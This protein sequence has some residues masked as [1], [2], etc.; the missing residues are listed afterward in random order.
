MIILS[1]FEFFLE[2]L[3]L[4]CIFRLLEVDNPKITFSRFFEIHVLKVYPLL[5]D[6]F[7]LLVKLDE[8]LADWLI[9][10]AFGQK[11][12]KKMS[13][14]LDEITN[15]NPMVRKASEQLVR[16][17]MNK[18]MQELERRRKFFLS[19][20]A[21]YILDAKIEEKLDI[22]RNMRNFGLDFEVISQMTGL[23]KEDIEKLS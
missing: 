10:F 13:S 1:K 20:K 6:D 16:L 9:F 23:S 5:K 17:S 18:E 7:S 14:A 19:D 12:E 8:G 21:Q 4:H 3:K 2:I 15:R 11:K 22:A